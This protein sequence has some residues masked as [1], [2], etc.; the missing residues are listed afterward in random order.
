MLC[1][2]EF[3]SNFIIGSAFDVVWRAG[4]NFKCILEPTFKQQIFMNFK[5]E[6]KMNTS[7]YFTFQRQCRGE[8][9]Q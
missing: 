2:V 4:P 9:Q 6:I 8:K 1:F 3:R 7:R 5:V